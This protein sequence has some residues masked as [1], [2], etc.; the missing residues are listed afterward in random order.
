MQEFTWAK[1]RLLAS[2]GQLRS[3]KRHAAFRSVQDGQ[4]L[5]DAVES[6]RMLKRV[7]KK[8]MAEAG[9]P[10]VDVTANKLRHMVGATALPHIP[11]YVYRSHL[12]HIKPTY[13]FHISAIYVLY[14]SH[15]RLINGR[16]TFHIRPI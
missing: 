1:S 16:Y 8:A 14:N 11:L 6:G 5:K 4:P 7:F 9:L 3:S 2:Y 10:P 12:G 15:I 13:T